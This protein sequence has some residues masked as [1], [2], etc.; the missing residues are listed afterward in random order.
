MVQ[1]SLILFVAFVVVVPAVISALAIRHNRGWIAGVL[2]VG[3][4]AGLLINTASASAPSFEAIDNQVFAYFV[5]LPAFLGSLAGAA[6]GWW[7]WRR[8]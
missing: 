6:F 5:F 1:V 8:E 3:C 7:K 2:S 4:L